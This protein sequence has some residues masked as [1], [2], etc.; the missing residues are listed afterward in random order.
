MP[1]SSRDCAVMV[2]V[3]TP[4]RPNTGRSCDINVDRGLRIQ[5]RVLDSGGA[6]VAGATVNAEQMAP[7]RLGDAEV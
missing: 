6:P 4:R 2:R 5:G 3:V 7:V 1:S